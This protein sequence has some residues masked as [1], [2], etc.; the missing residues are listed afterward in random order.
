VF[1]S[2]EKEKKQHKKLAVG[3]GDASGTATPS[4]VTVLCIGNQ[5]PSFNSNHSLNKRLVSL[6]YSKF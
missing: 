1:K 4:P 5:R 6:I 2:E 3:G